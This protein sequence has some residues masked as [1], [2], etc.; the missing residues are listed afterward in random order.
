MRGPNLLRGPHG[1]PIRRD[2][3]PTLPFDRG[4]IT[5]AGGGSIVLLDSCLWCKARRE[6]DPGRRVARMTELTADAIEIALK[7]LEP[8]RPN[9]CC[10][11]HWEGFMKL[12][13]MAQ[14][15]GGEAGLRRL[16]RAL[17]VSEGGS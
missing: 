14:E 16:R 7:K 1:R 5:T 13:K 3:S 17:D 10:P 11:H 9:H 2:R 6:L 8:R 15:E 12:R 4:T